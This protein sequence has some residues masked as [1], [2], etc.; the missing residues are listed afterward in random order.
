LDEIDDYK[1]IKRNIVRKLLLDK[2]KDQYL[3]MDIDLDSWLFNV[4]MPY[5]MKLVNG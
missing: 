5:N 4:S 3:I 2:I 1:L